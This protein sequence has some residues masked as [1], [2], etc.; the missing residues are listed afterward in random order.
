MSEM[1]RNARRAMRAKIHRLT[2]STSGKVD[3]SDY[4]PEET[5]DAG[6]KT[7]MRPVSRRAFKKGGKVVANEGADAKQ[8]AGK[9]SRAGSKHLTIDGL[10]NRN[11][12]DANEARE[13]KKH[14]GGLKRGGKAGGGPLSQMGGDLYGLTSN[15]NPNRKTMLKKG[16]AAKKANGG[17]NY[18]IRV[19]I[20]DADETV[21]DHIGQ[22][23]IAPYL[24]DA[25]IAA[26]KAAAAQRKQAED[27]AV[28]AGNRELPEKIPPSLPIA[29]KKGGKVPVRQWENSSKDKAQDKKLAKRH[30]ESFEEWEESAADRKH[31]KQQSMKGL[32]HGGEV[33]HVECECKKCGGVAKARGGKLTSLDGEMQTQEKVGDRIA[34]RDGGSLAGLELAS[35]GRAKGKGKTNINIVIGADGQHPRMMPP[36]GMPPPP[37]GLPIPVG[38]PP[39]MGGMPPMGGGMPPMGPPPM[40][41]GMPPMG[42]PGGG[43]PPMGPPGGMP[44]MGRKRGGRAGHYDFGAGGGKGRLEKIQEYGEKQKK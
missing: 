25:Q 11:L 41:G 40:G 30:H 27:A 5:I 6:V 17:V 18:P 13:G 29:H 16:G 19:P 42:P 15:P 14:I 35:G 26:A 20:K 3:A 43:M 38:G 23:G 21:M 9:K 7:G 24:K 33:H 44:P 22:V 37:Q 31:D 2:Q 34:K 8:N 4:G 39:P 28:A 32:K 1:S 36:G 12:K 10:I